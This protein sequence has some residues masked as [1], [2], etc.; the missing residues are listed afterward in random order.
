VPS[1]NHQHRVCISVV[2]PCFNEEESL[3]H[4]HARLTAVMDGV[5]A[6]YEIVYVND[7]SA[8]RTDCLLRSIQESDPNVRV[9]G[10]SRNFGQQVAITAGL[11]HA[12]GDAAVLIDADLQDPP[13]LISAM[14]TE[15]RKGAKVVYGVRTDRDGESQFKLWT[16]K[17]F[18]RVL[19]SLAEVPIPLD[20]GDF[21]LLDRVV[22][23]A[24]V[25]MPERARFI[26]GMAS[27]VGYLQVPLP[28]QR[29]ARLAG[30]T[31][32]SL[33]KMLRLA[34]D[35]VVSFSLSPL[36]LATLTGMMASA[37]A[38]LGIGYAIAARVLTNHW[39][40]GWATIF[41]A[42]LFLGGVQLLCLG[43]MG[44]YIG[45]IYG[46]AKQRP[47][48]FLNERLGFT[49]QTVGCTAA[50]KSFERVANDGLAD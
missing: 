40:P 7:G 14:V 36:R 43:I 15:W 35:G 17:A 3:E 12:T 29:Q 20:T 26:R 34:L 25:T 44:E 23:D 6:D 28:Y 32:Y 13:E 39:V 45:R 22:I 47:L 30:V 37:L 24:L 10:L 5:G 42:V 46:E 31:K 18:Y 8:D 33:F 4:T 9:I 2:V 50:A 11:S 38:V 21:R 48:Y 41:V 49:D 27:W 16:A 1:A 19:N